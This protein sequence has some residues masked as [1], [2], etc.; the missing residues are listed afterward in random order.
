MID[1]GRRFTVWKSADPRAA[2]VIFGCGLG[3]LAIG[4]V[5]RSGFLEGMGAGLI[6]VGGFTLVSRK[7]RS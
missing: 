4:A 6:L 5:L 3:A 7:V 2:L 1:L